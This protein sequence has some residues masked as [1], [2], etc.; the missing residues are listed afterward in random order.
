MEP[1]SLLPTLRQPS[2]SPLTNQG[3]P[4]SEADK[5]TLWKRYRQ[6]LRQHGTKKRAIEL[7]TQETGRGRFSLTKMLG[8]LEEANPPPKRQMEIFSNG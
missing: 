7:L 2:H 5:E 6:L 1:G 8:R 3:K 4:W